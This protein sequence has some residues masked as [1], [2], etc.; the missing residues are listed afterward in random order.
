MYSTLFH[1]WWNR[2]QMQIKTAECMTFIIHNVNV[3]IR[4]C[5]WQT[6]REPWRSSRG[7][8]GEPWG[9]FCGSWGSWRLSCCSWGASR[10]LWGDL[11]SLRGSVGSCCCSRYS[12]EDSWFLWSVLK[13]SEYSG[14]EVCVL[15]TW[16]RLTGE[17]WL[18]LCVGGYKWHHISPGP[19]DGEAVCWRRLPHR[20]P[21]GG[22]VSGRH[23][24]QQ[25]TRTD[26]L[27][28]DWDTECSQQSGSGLLILR[29]KRHPSP[30]Y[31]CKFTAD[32][33]CLVA[34]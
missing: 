23:W 19:A 17:K 8:W 15:V 24:H 11:G 33:C 1:C 21:S 10:G 13:Y 12:S 7:L 20:F 30:P 18:S 9:S 31:G 2:L 14:G 32:V 34:R 26:L 6:V 27:Q 25:R 16:T 3:L 28:S 22:S 29:K 4:M 5:F